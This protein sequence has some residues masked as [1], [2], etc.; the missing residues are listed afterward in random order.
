MQVFDALLGAP[1]KL[2][3]I[4]ELNR[5][6]GTRLRTSGGHI[7]AKPI[8]AKRTFPGSSIVFLPVDNAERAIHYAVSAAV[9]DIGLDINRIEFCA[10]NCAGGTTFKAA[11]ASAVLANIGRKQPRERSR[12]LRLECDRPFDKCDVPPGGRAEARC[13]VVG[14][15][16]EIVSVIRQL[17]PLLASH[18][19][20]LAS[21]AKSRVGEKALGH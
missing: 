4:A 2:I 17:V 10:N 16:G 8:V 5:L 18:L 15:A 13:I 21:D 3:K 1:P 6:G 12:I 20:R 19:A 11:R 14:H 7:G 9:A